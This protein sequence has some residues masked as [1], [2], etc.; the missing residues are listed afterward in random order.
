MSEPDPQKPAGPQRE[1]PDPGKGFDATLPM[2]SRSPRAAARPVEPD[3]EEG[4]LDLDLDVSD[5]E[6]RLP[7]GSE[8]IADK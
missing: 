7:Y 4:D 3:A 6:S 1:K 5:I 8:D 2:A